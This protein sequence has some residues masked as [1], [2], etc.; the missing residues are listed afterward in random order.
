MSEKRHASL[1][2]HHETSQDDVHPVRRH[3]ILRRAKIACAVVLVLLAIGAGRTVVSRIANAHALETNVAEQSKQYVTTVQAKRTDNAN[4]LTLPGTLQGY[5]EAPIYARSSGYL[6]HWYKDIGSHVKKG[7]LL[8]DIDTPEIDQ[9]LS[10]AIA[11][12]QQAA[13]NL[14]L[15]KSSAERWESMRQKD[16]VSQQELDER[17]SAFAQAKANLAAADANTRRLEQLESFKRIIAPFDGI[18]TRRNIDVGG[19]VD[20]GNGGSGRA[21]FSLAQVDPLRIYVSVPQAYAAMIKQGQAVTV[22]QTELAGQIFQ[23]VVARMAGAIDATTRTMQI[24][25]NIPNHDSKLLPG[26]Y[27]EVSLP[28]VK[29]QS[30]VALPNTLLFRSEGPRVAIVDGTGHV[31]L[32]PVTIGRD[33]G[34]SIEILSGIGENDRLILNPSDSLADGDVVVISRAP[35]AGGA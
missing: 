7:E 11:S 28:V 34:K 15:A 12:R 2:I 9:Q 33:L 25:I 5:V 17:R 3:T 20:A 1:G 27:V 13:A 10:Q 26:A 23:G 16:V 6:L 18:V 8:A 22:K 29:S 31:K 21:L 24:E 30:L 32:Q 4:A 35:A 14:E 19:L